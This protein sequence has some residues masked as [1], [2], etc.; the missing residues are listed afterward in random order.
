MTE[1]TGQHKAKH[2]NGKAGNHRAG[3]FAAGGA[4]QLREAL[5]P[6][7]TSRTRAHLQNC[8]SAYEERYQDRPDKGMHS[9][10]CEALHYCLMGQ[11]EDLLQANAAWDE[12]NAE[13]DGEWGLPASYF[14]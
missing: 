5:L 9:H 6:V 2:Q 13:I 1:K 11:G 10:V 3:K 4:A 7:L 12:V 8:L 14:E